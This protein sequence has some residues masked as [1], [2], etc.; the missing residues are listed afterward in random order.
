MVQIDYR[1]EGANN[2]DVSHFF[3]SIGGS[4]PAVYLFNFFCPSA[5]KTGRSLCR[6]IR[7]LIVM[8]G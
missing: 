4:F 1:L 5:D 7:N 8:D 6:L 3:S 2:K